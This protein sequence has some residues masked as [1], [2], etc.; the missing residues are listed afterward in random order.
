MSDDP[1][2]KMIT[3]GPVSDQLSEDLASLRMT[4]EPE[5]RRRSLVWKV[6]ATVITLLG[7]GFVV[8]MY[9]SKLEAWA[10]QVEVETGEIAMVSPAQASV[11]VTTTGH[12][13]AQNQSRIGVTSPGRIAKVH[14]KEGDVV[15]EGDALLE[16]D[17]AGDKSAV[18]AARARTTAAR[19][20]ADAARASMEELKQQIE[21]ERVLVDRGVTGKAKLD[22][23]TARLRSLEKQAAA[24]DA[25]TGATAA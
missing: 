11:T 8:V 15:K 24:A 21:R 10:F 18:A 3:S 14:V 19:A 4:D 1:E 16:L 7:I 13:V 6:V 25:E 2:S 20:H 23:L 17:D 9:G 22:D 12:V 5:P